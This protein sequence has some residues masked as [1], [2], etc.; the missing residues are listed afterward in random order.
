MERREEFGKL[1]YAEMKK[2][3]A[4]TKEDRRNILD[5]EADTLGLASEEELKGEIEFMVQTLNLLNCIWPK[6]RTTRE[7]IICD[8]ELRDLQKD[9]NTLKLHWCCKRDWEKKTISATPKWHLLFYH[10]IDVLTK[11]RRICHMAED[12]VERTHAEDKH[13]ERNFAHI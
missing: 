3:I 8:E 2:C 9:I 10:M 11:Y 7:T 13:L 4:T 5:G 6:I 12:P 1:L